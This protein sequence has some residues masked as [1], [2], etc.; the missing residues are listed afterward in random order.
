VKDNLNIEKLFKDKFENF[1]GDLSPDLWGNISKGISSKAVVSSGIGLGVKALI[2]G[3]SAITVGVTAYFVGNFTQPTVQIVE[4]SVNV[5]K[6]VLIEEVRTVQNIKNNSPERVS[7]IADDNDPVISE[8]K[9]EII[10]ELSNTEVVNI[11]SAI[12]EI[13]NS[14]DDTEV[15][16]GENQAETEKVKA[17]AS[18]VDLIS[19][20]ADVNLEIEVESE[21][22]DAITDE[23]VEQLAPSGSIEN[24]PSENI[25]EYE[26]RSNG[27]N[28][29]KVSWDFGDGYTSLDN[30]PR[31]IYAKPGIYNVKLILIADNGLVYNETETIEIISIASIDNLPNVFTPNGDRVND[32]FVIETTEIIEFMITIK[33]RQG[34]TVFKSNDKN[35]I[36]DGT[37]MFGN[38]SDKAIYTYYIIAKGTD[39]A[40]FK[41]P[42]QLSLVR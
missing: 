37:D 38:V 42:G 16:F 21:E 31:H 30:N 33:N 12:T 32:E 28:C 13:D 6:P 22:S 36:W 23:I 24:R 18:E 4:N 9:A 5:E 14:G 8:N 25:F 29:E 15:S 17:E 41:I 35:F 10:K 11:S 2:V 20:T 26:F 39:G 3:V 34:R 19:N 40:I 1:E 27:Q 7:I